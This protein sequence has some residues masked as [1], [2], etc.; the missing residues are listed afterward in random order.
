MNIRREKS[1]FIKAKTTSNLYQSYSFINLNQ[2]KSNDNLSILTNYVKKLEKI[3]KA[4]IEE[5]INLKTE[6]NKNNEK[7]NQKYKEENLSLIKEYSKGLELL[8]PIKQIINKNKEP[9]N[10]IK[11]KKNNLKTIIDNKENDKNEGNIFDI[12][13][14]SFNEF[15]DIQELKNYYEGKIELLEKKIEVMEALE[16][17]YSEQYDKYIKN[18]KA[19]NDKKNEKTENGTINENINK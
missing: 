1:P 4:V 2:I 15:D 13:K 14:K 11:N 17:I 9:F 12:C 8:I 16:R 18:R 6:L 7:E 10:E 19:K 5:N 3:L